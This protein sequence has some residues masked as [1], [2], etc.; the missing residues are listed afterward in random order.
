MECIL[1]LVERQGLS[2]VFLA[3]GVAI[4]GD[5]IMLHDDAEDLV[6]ANPHGL[7]FFHSLHVGEECSVPRLD[8]T[9]RIL[10]DKAFQFFFKASKSR[11]GELHLRITRDQEPRPTTRSNNRTRRT[12]PYVHTGD[13]PP[14]RLF[15]VE[16]RGVCLPAPSPRDVGS[17]IESD[18]SE[19]ELRE[20]REG[21]DAALTGLWLQFIQDVAQKVSNRKGTSQE[22]YCKLSA[23]TRSA[24][25][26]K[27]YKN[28]I[29]SDFF[30]DCQ[31]KEATE[32]EWVAAFEH[33]FPLVN[34]LTA[35]TVQ[36]YGTRYYHIWEEIKKRAG[37]E[38]AIKRLRQALKARFDLLSW[39]PCA[40][41]DRIWATRC[42]PSRFKKF[43]NHG[44]P[45]PWI[46]VW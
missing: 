29:L 14:P 33:L 8:P 32:V 7:V 12:R 22:R 16:E 9:P 4:D 30:N 40:Q 23:E 21:A 35:V 41:A 39:F 5:I 15:N 28:L 1:P 46:L 18:E 42:N 3:Y 10:S 36:N 24:A 6:P 44:K 37:N 19:K 31:W 26:E 13:A 2:D 17:D 27:L 20:V 43:V 45:A 11:F 34:K 25:N 38:D